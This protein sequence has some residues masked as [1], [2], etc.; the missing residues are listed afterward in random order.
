MYIWDL[1]NSFAKI[2]NIHMPF[3]RRPSSLC[4][5]YEYTTTL[6]SSGD[7]EEA[8]IAKRKPKKKEIYRLCDG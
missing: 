4:E 7:E 3:F 2:R 5:D 1:I 8:E 6:E